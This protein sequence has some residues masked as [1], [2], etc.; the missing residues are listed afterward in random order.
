VTVRSVAHIG[1]RLF[2]GGTSVSAVAQ[3]VLV[4]LL[5]LGLNFATGVIVARGLGPV[6]RGELSALVIWPPFLT[7]MFVMGIPNAF[8]FYAQRDPEDKDS[9]FTASMIVTCALSVAMIAAGWFGLPFMLKSYSAA[10]LDQARLFLF[11]APEIMLSYIAGALLQDAH[12]FT[13]IN[14]QRYV[15]VA[16]TLV[17]LIVLLH[18]GT[19]T[20]FSAALCYLV[21]PIPIAVWAMLRLRSLVRPTLRGFASSVRRIVHY[22]ARASGTS[23]LG[24]IAQQVDQVLVISLLSATSMGVYAVALSV[25]RVPNFVFQAMV[26]VITAK[27]MR[28]GPAELTSFVG[29]GVR[30]ALLAGGLCALALAVVLPVILPLFYG[31][32]FRSAVVVCDILLCELAASGVASVLSIAYL[33]SGRPGMVTIVHGFS[34][35]VT[36]PLMFVLIPRLGLAGAALSLLTSSACRLV[37]LFVGYRRAVGTAPP[38]LVVDRDD[39]RFIAGYVRSVVPGMP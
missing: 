32:D 39:L 15:P 10:T 12:R 16:A 34:L 33:A 11:L 27:A 9:L 23:L 21:P 20:S 36:V 2:G 18:L 13:F 22:G 3:T 25:S 8:L 28:L 30:F 24:T 5:L 7:S 35:L 31:A 17:G 14:Q 38:R 29:R 1:R 4:R 37:A 26:E 6:G 19:L